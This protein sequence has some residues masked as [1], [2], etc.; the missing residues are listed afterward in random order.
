MANGGLKPRD[1]FEVDAKTNVMESGLLRV[2]TTRSSTDLIENGEWSAVGDEPAIEVIVEPG[3][4]QTEPPPVNRTTEA[5][6]QPE[7]A[8]PAAEA[9]VVAAEAPTAEA[10]VAAPVAAASERTDFVGTPPPRRSRLLV[11]ATIVGVLLLLAEVSVFVVHRRAPRAQPAPAPLP[12]PL[13]KYMLLPIAAP[14]PP[15]QPAADVAEAPAVMVMPQNE[16]K[17]I[18]R[19]PHTRD[20]GTRTHHRRSKSSRN[21]TSTQ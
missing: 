5:L 1:D 13:P 6:L 19:A 14:P 21:G 16:L 2:L 3:Q 7:S 15:P 12:A 9:P 18:P 8:A 20:S 11:G 10:P 4:Q 17:P